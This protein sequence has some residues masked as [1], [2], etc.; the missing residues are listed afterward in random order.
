M[1]PIKLLILIA[2]TGLMMACAP[3][4][5]NDVRSNIESHQNLGAHQI[6]IS[7]QRS[8]VTLTGKVATEAARAEIE[9][10]TLQTPGVEQVRNRVVVDPTLSGSLTQDTSPAASRILK[11]VREDRA[12][13]APYDLRV[14]VIGTNAFLDGEVGNSEDA[15]RIEAVA[16]KQPGINSVTNRLKTASPLSDHEITGALNQ[17]V[18]DIDEQGFQ[19]L[20]FE[21]NS[22]V[23]TFHGDAKDHT[24]VD[25]LL[26]DVNML[27]GVKSVRNEITI[28]G[29]P[30]MEAWKAGHRATRG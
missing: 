29:K 18:S 27:I 20:K 3:R 25:R 13:T 24:V 12:F 30:Y 6:N 9:R 8:T 14:S 23:I 11:A 26:A 19:D 4:L 10:L 7:N 15:K 1:K 28:D 22:G 2:L 16:L 5:A 21:V 17:I